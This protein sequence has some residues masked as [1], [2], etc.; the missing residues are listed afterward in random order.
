MIGSMK[1]GLSV[2]IP[3]YNEEE[4]TAECL[5]T[6]HK[7]LK[8]SDYDWEII[9]VNDG[10]KDRTGEI[11]KSFLPKIKHLKIVENKPNRGYGG[12]LKAGFARA[13]KEFIAFTPADNQ[14]DFSEIH[15]LVRLQQETNADI[16]SGIRL[17]GGV[18]PFMR[19]VNRFGWNSI[20]TLLFGRL[21]SDVDC[22][23]KL[24]RRSILEKISLTSNG[25][26]IDTQLFAGAKS[27]G[28]KIA[29][30]PVT[31]LPRTAGNPTGAKISVILK[32]FKELFRFWWQLR[33][34]ILSESGLSVSR[35]EIF[36]L[37]LILLV[38]AFARLYRIDSYMTFLGDEGRDMLVVRDII[39]GRHFPSI[40]PGTSVG[41]MYLGPLYYYL[42]APALFFSGLSPVGPAVFVALIGVATVGLMWWIGRR[43]FGSGAALAVS[44]LYGLSPAVITYSR[45]SWNPNVMP[46]FAL[47]FMYGIWQV[48]RR[49]RWNWL[50]I[51]SICLAFVLNSHYL[52]LLLLPAAGLFWLI[53]PKGPL[54]RRKTLHGLLWFAV[55]MSPLLFFDVRHGW[56]NFQAVSTFFSNRQTTVNLKVY[57]A[58]P[59]LS[60]IW[61]DL[62]SQTVT[63]GNR[64]AGLFASWALIVFVIFTVIKNRRHVNPDLVFVSVWL[65]TGLL[66]LGLYKQH[67]YLHYYGFIFPAVFFLLGFLLKSVSKTKF[68][69]IVSVILVLALLG[70]N[71]SRNPLFFE[72]NDQLHRTSQV[73]DFIDR[74]SAGQPYN[75]ALVSKTNYDASYRYLLTLK[76]SPYKQIHDQITDQL[77]VI[78]E[79]TDCQ[80]I[81]NPLWEIASFGW[82][83]VDRKWTFT[84]GTVL[85]RLVK[86]PQGI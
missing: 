61:H 32:A 10:S 69:L 82:A 55:L 79:N 5:T 30:T 50:V 72:P 48:W 4:N 43:W 11:A 80:P 66:G 7:I 1:L 17:G 65:F 75:L 21:A 76:N 6:V 24:F 28:L 29:E 19:R 46:F 9:F 14:F 12:S 22:G 56:K 26:L 8:Q 67:I 42:I 73:V 16:V 84:W 45:S 13:T 39:L 25:A 40:G 23:F 35:P 68:G 83:K 62:I 49:H 52:G 85:Y 36:L 59:N 37:V 33:R 74:Q 15:K 47:L 38:S 78:C 20:V 27:R 31:H 53:T 70:L 60:P 34:E 44:A 64:Q 86:N 18:D 2:V 57:K 81:N 58:I 3:A 71:L 54:A 41:S 51:S 77:F 63:A